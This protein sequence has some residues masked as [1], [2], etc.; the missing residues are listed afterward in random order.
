MD[1]E[2]ERVLPAAKRAVIPDAT[3][4][5]CAEYPKVCAAEITRFITGAMDPSRSPK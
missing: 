4:D 1:A 3:H 5:V 2:L